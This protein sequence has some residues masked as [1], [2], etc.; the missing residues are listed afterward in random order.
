MLGHIVYNGYARTLK[1]WFKDTATSTPELRHTL[2]CHDIGVNDGL[3]DDPYG[4]YCMCPPGDYGVSAPEALVPPEIP[5]GRWF[6][7]LIDTN[8]NEAKHG[9]AGIG[10]HGGGSAAPE[11]FIPRQGWY[12]TEGCFRLQN[13]D[14]EDTLVPFVQYVLAHGGELLHSVVQPDHPL[15]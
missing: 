10:F 7:G 3:L 4:I 15:A 2:E 6:I 12:A 13:I 9:R 14:L 5:Y 1:L 11:P 8:G